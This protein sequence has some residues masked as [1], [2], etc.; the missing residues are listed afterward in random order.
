M[1][2]FFH[3]LEI[4]F[5]QL[6][7]FKVRFLQVGIRNDTDLHVKAPLEAKG[8]RLGSLKATRPPKIKNLWSITSN[9]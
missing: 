8:L 3:I 2:D 4:G 1:K 9:L 6:L 5:N 7:E